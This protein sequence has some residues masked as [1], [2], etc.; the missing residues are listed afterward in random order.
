MEIHDAHG[1]DQSIHGYTHEYPYP[2][3]TWF[4]IEAIIAVQVNPNYDRQISVT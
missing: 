3:Q 4:L 1:Y 2:R